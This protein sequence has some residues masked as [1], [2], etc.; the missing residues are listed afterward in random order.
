MNTE[1]RKSPAVSVIIPAYKAHNTLGRALDSIRENECSFEII[2]S[3]DDRGDYRAFQGESVFIHE[4]TQLRSG[5]GEARN[6]GLSAAKGAYIA[7]LDAD[8]TYAPGYLDTLLPIARKHK[9]AFSRT[10]VFENDK[11]ILHLATETKRLTFTEIAKTGASFWGLFHKTLCGP[12]QTIPSQDIIHTLEIL[13]LCGGAGELGNVD[14]QLRTNTTSITA[15]DDFSAKVEA[16]YKQIIADIKA[17]KTRAHQ[18]H[19]L[20]IID[21][22]KRKLELNANFMS[23]G[24]DKSYYQYIASLST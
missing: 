14:Y 5:P 20:Q 11:P 7:F 1:P 15:D 18:N 10:T 4:S 23:D 21:V 16:G 2:I 3:V 9:A 12:F 22:W 19:H 8:D 17:G 13:S 24:K 6:R